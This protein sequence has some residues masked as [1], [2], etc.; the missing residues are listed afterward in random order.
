MPDAPHH[1]WVFNQSRDVNIVSGEATI[2]GIAM[3]HVN[4]LKRNAFVRRI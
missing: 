4:N 2:Y 1:Y 3:S